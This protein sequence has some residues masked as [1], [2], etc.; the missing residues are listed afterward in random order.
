M[1]LR[2]L[3]VKLSSLG[4]VVH[5]YPALSDLKRARPDVEVDWLVEEAFTGLAGLHPAVRKTI[6][7]HLR[8]MKKKSLKDK[9]VYTRALRT[10]L[11]GRYDLVIDAQG[12][13]KSAV[14]ARLAGAPVAGYAREHAREPWA[15]LAYKHKFDLTVMQN[16]A[17]RTRK[18]FAAAVGYDLEGLPLDHGLDVKGLATQ[19]R[20]ILAKLRINKP[21]A[22]ILHGSA[23]PTKTWAPE[24]W[25][26]V[27]RHLDERGIPLV[28]P[29]GG[30]DELET[31]VAISD[32][33][34]H[35]RVLPPLSLVELAGVLAVARTVAG[36]DSGLTH[37]AEAL[38]KH[39]LFL[40]GPTDP[41]RTGP[42]GKNLKTIVSSH[43]AAPCYKRSCTLT[44]GGRCCMDAI[45]ER[46]VLRAVDY[47]LAVT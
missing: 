47:A 23:W 37:L 9:I 40:I 36:V 5:T 4:D 15:A 3:V 34:D 14:V 33:L 18:L 28:I 25:R 26:A 38:G 39:G 22:V 30:A 32:G 1:S 45:T 6:P 31:A 43:P 20:T 8:A 42:I 11:K 46:E 16:A 35:A 24:R 19:G 2:V 10:A 13:I 44:P 7:A 41:V 17:T 21:P 12:L 27:A 29:A